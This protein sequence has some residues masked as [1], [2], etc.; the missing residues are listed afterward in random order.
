MVRFEISTEIKRPVA[1][2]FAYT[3]DPNN[4]P[5]WNA[6]VEEARASETPLRVGSTIT[7]RARFLGR[8]IDSVNQVTEYVVNQKFT[9]TSEK[10]FPITIS[11][12]FAAIDGGTKVTATLEGEPGGFFKL[13]EP[14][15][16]RIAKKQFQTQLDTLKELLEAR[17]PAEVR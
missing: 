1:E 14:I 8:K 6:I 13:G 3:V 7:G 15:L 5:E 10:P 4:L 17:T 11:N 2:V 16:T 9:Q 12:L